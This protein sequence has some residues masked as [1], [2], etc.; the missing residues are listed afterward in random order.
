MADITRDSSVLSLPFFLLFPK[1]Y[2]I[3]IGGILHWFPAAL[4]GEEP[5]D[6]MVA[7][8]RRADTLLI[9]GTSTLLKGP[10]QYSLQLKSTLHWDGAARA[11][12]GAG[13]GQ[14]V[15]QITVSQETFNRN[16]ENG[17]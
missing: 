14:E 6:G 12:A 17:P 4:P 16:K 13:K 15:T 5:E 1:S 2:P 10:C 7:G 8:G 9:A 11:S 3:K